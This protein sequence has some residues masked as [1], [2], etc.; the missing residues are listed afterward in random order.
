MTQPGREATTYCVRGGH[1]YLY[2]NK[3]SWRVSSV[4]PFTYRITNY[5]LII[6]GKDTTLKFQ[7][8]FNGLDPRR[9]N[10]TDL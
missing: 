5:I 2:G 8:N 7:N 4:S 1:A 10:D 6:Y 3:P 9:A